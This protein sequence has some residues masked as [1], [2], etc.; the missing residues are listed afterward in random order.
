MA[1]AHEL[2]E[3][4]RAAPVLAAGV[5]YVREELVFDV[6]RRYLSRD[7]RDVDLFDRGTLH[8]PP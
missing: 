2:V 6:V 8:T 3:V 5:L 4:C 1:E 7:R